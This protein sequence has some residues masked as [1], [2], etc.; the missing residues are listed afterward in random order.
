[1]RDLYLTSL[2]QTDINHTNCLSEI[3]F[4]AAEQR[5]VEL[6][7][8]FQQSRQTVGPLHGLPIS[9]KDRFNVNGLESASGY[10]S[11]IGDIK[12]LEDEGLLVRKLQDAGAIIFVK[13]NVPTSMLIG[14]TTNNIIGSTINPYNREL[15]AG[16]ASGGEGALLAMRGSPL[17]WGSDIAG[18]IRIPCSFNHLFGLRPSYGRIS[19]TGMTTTLPGLPT[20][21]SV[22][23]PMATDLESICMIMRWILN[24]SCWEDDPHVIPM[25]WRDEYMSNS[26]DNGDVY[27]G[28]NVKFAFGI[29]YDDNEVL[30][31]P[32]VKRAMKLVTEALRQQGHEVSSSFF[33]L[34][35]VNLTYH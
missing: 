32:P 15:T 21:M 2:A 4:G 10:V 16:G 29:M 11:W 18:S 20:A 1:M 26:Q 12:T 25:P 23:G 5:A 19:S 6:D 22:V 30:P 3:C 9:L 34:R 33:I 13:T 28:D 7:L 24:S 31:H 14:E 27:F 8:A 35:I 17:G